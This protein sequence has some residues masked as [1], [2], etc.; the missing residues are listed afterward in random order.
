MDVSNSAL[1]LDLNT[2]L[3]SDEGYK[4][5]L[6]AVCLTTGYTDAEPVKNK[7][8][9]EVLLAFKEMKR[10]KIIKH[11]AGIKYV[12]TDGGSEFLGEFREFLLKNH[13]IPIVE[14]NYNKNNMAVVER[15]VSLVTQ[16]LLEYLA[17]KSLLTRRNENK[18]RAVLPKIIFAINNSYKR[19]NPRSTFDMLEG[20]PI[21][22]K[23]VI[24]IGTLVHRQL[25]TARHILN[26]KEKYKYRHGDP[27]FT[28]REY[29]V[30]GYRIKMGKPLRYYLSD[31]ME[32]SYLPHQ[33]L[34]SNKNFEEQ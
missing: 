24:P 28:E 18:W 16:P 34:V 1:Q 32:I 9:K 5:I 8:A 6:I 14:N 23:R 22:P 31:N 13:M 15:A 3:I 20:P 12:I 17:R 11:I 29:I 2:D 19:N 33:L 26:N 7:E 10:R 30:S 27:R 21:L 25:D 4:H